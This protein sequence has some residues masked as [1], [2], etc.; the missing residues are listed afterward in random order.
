MTIQQLSVFIE[1][2]PGNLNKV[3]AV[4]ADN[5]INIKALTIADTADFGIVRLIVSDPQ[6]AFNA[7]RDKH[8]SVQLQDILS[9][10]MAPEPGSLYHI[11]NLFATENVSLEYVYAFSYGSKSILVLRTDNREKA[12]EIIRK[13]NLKS[14]TE[15]DLK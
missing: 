12:V 4:L 11:L 7:L 1:N 6:K 3:L 2:H 10:E 8:F 9:V 15:A 14:V 5:S 13:N